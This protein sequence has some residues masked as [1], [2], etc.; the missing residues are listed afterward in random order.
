MTDIDHG[1]PLGPGE[2]GELWFRSLYRMSGY[3]TLHETAAATITVE[4]W[5]RTGDIGHLDD[6]GYVYIDDPSK[7]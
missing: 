2:Q 6:D 7:I 1:T 3:L 5:L 4:G